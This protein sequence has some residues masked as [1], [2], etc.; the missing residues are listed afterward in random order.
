MQLSSV[1]VS[2]P[3]FCRAIMR[4]KALWSLCAKTTLKLQR[5]STIRK[6]LHPTHWAAAWLDWLIALLI[7]LVSL[8]L[9][10]SN[11]CSCLWVFWRAVQGQA[12]PNCLQREEKAS[13]FCGEQFGHLQWGVHRWP[14]AG[15]ESRHSLFLFQ[16]Q[17]VHDKWLQSLLIPNRIITITFFPCG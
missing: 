9:E 10:E 1:S 16:A 5:Y 4:Q 6:D 15:T 14:S 7:S 12:G 17:C 3:S 2:I 8:I 13:S 11:K